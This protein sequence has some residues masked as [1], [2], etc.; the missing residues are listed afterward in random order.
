MK[1]DVRFKTDALEVTL[2]ESLPLAEDQLGF[3]GAI[4]SPRNRERLDQLGDLM[5]EF[6]EELA[7]DPDPSP[8]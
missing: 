3:L 4:S 5:R 1:Y 2:T 8:E 6:L 7:A